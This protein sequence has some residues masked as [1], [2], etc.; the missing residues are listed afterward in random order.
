MPSEHVSPTER[1]AESP[2]DHQDR[3]T[4]T[5]VTTPGDGSCG[6]GT[7]ARDLVEQLDDVD[8][9]TV[10][11]PQDDRSIRRFVALAVRT[12]RPGSDVVH[13]QHEYGLFRRD[14][15][16]YP[17]VMGLVYFPLLFLLGSLCSARVVVTMHS[18]LRPQADEAPFSVRLY[19]LCMHKLLASGAAH[20]VFLS[21]DCAETFLADIDLGPGE[22]S[23]LSHGV[24]TDLPE[25]PRG[26]AKRHLGYDPE[27]AVVAIPG[28]VRP[29]K[30]HDI[31]VEVARRLP[32]YEFLVAGGA[33]PKG[34]DFAFAERIRAEAPENVTVTGPLDDEDYWTTLAAPDLAL[35]PYRVVTQSGTFNA[36]AS[37]RLP[38][39]ASDADY[40]TRIQAK[41]SA[42]ETV[43]I[44]DVDA[45]VERVRTLAEDDTQRH[46][47]ADAIRRYKRANSFEQV[48]ADHARI[49]R[50]V[51]D[52][53][54]AELGDADADAN[55]DPDPEPSTMSLAACSAQRS[56]PTD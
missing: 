23:V 44:E 32:E 11:V 21:P 13:V 52:D 30:G 41:W 33:R 29:P 6:I 12:I 56:L 50:H 18:V 55:P 7:Y 31:F 16:R 39:L 22:Y 46:R 26:V 42:P 4:V 35:L 49:Y 45:V 1:A 36:C 9:E 10:H 43:D 15:S 2:T 53:I 37:R 54:D 40:F 20:L 5:V 28:F 14:G 25:V 27:D 38:V 34:D 3:P 17:G 8:A 48:A 24:V 51:A 47:L 19:L